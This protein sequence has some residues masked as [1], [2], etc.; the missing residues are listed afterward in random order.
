[1]AVYVCLLAVLGSQGIVVK[2]T[3][4]IFFCTVDWCHYSL[5]DKQTKHAVEFQ[6]G[7]ITSCPNFFIGAGFSHAAFCSSAISTLIRRN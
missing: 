3:A 6:D 5:A 2:C 7:Q 4:A 1:M